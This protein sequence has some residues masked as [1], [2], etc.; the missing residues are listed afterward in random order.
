MV[1]ILRRRATKDQKYREALGIVEEISS[2]HCI[3]TLFSDNLV[4]MKTKDLDLRFASSLYKKY[5][6]NKRI[7]HTFKF[8]EEFNLLEQRHQELITRPRYDN[9]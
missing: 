1:A 2:L 5:L 4:Y 7:I 8:T 6:Q 3:N 9:C